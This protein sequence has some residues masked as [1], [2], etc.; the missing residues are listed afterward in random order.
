MKNKFFDPVEL[1]AKLIRCRS[2]TPKEG[3]AIILVG[4]I[5]E[6]HGFVCSQIK[7]GGITNLFA[8]WGQH[9]GGRNF[10]FNGH[11]DVVPEGNISKWTKN[12][13]GADIEAGFMYGRGAVDMKSGVAAFVA[14]AIEYVENSP[15]DGSISIMITGDE[16]G[17]AKHGTKAILDWIKEKEERIDHCLVGEPT[18]K[19]ALGDTIKIG[20]RGSL[21]AKFSALGIQGHTAYPHKAKNPLPALVK[22]MDKLASYKLDQGSEHFEPSTLAITSIDTGNLA[23]NVI[24]SRAY[25]TVNIRFNDLHSGKSLG[26]WLKMECKQLRKQYNTE[27]RTKINISGESFYTKPGHL[28]QVMERAIKKVFSME[29]EL[30]T[31]GGT[32]DARFIREICPVIEFGLVGDTMHS[33][34]ERVAISQI[35]ELKSVYKQFLVEYF[36]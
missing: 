6:D 12:P 4:K 21:T 9:T 2:V 20:R 30:S 14:A 17:D 36:E 5:L 23:S 13:F 11:T 22:L 7:R 15:P 8:R 25:S 29:P 33:V 26:D 18:S 10:A 3:G 1:T 16:E 34:D 24:P 19:S 32:S 28:S 31:G 35:K 27:I